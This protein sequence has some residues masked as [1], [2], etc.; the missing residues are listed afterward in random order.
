MEYQTC[1]TL[2]GSIKKENNTNSTQISEFIGLN[3][4][5]REAPE[6]SKAFSL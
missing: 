5:N 4:Q 1:A 2:S 6:K 3:N